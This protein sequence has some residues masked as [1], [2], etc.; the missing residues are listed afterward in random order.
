MNTA[1]FLVRVERKQVE[2]VDVFS[3]QLVSADEQR[4]PTFAAGSH[5]DVHLA[6]GLTRQYSLCNDPAESHHYLIAVL[7]DHASRG[8]SETMHRV[9]REGDLLTISAPRNHFPLAP[10]GKSSLLFAGGI[11]ITPILCMS[12]RLARTGEDFQMHYC[13]RSHERTTF[14]HRIARSAFSEKVHFHLD[15]G[16]EEQRL[17]LEALLGNPR[18]YVHV[19]V[20]GPTGFINAV[21]AK[22]RGHGWPE[23]QLHYEFF[24]T[25]LVKTGSDNGFDVKLASSG[26][27]VRVAK[28]QSV[29]QALEAAG[30]NVTTSCEQGVCGACLTRVLEGEPDHRDTYLTVEERTQN[31]D[32]L[33]CCS[34]AKSSLLVLDL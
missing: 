22:A 17:D 24:G 15:D 16:C 1:T 3:Y 6:K 20:C 32:F 21:L 29:V 11:G 19:Y 10:G 9:V 4:L 18:E 2:A 5:I 25:N 23:P 27:I 14:R 34:R 33:P 28:N 8:G 31:R 30:V 26:R 12:E 13:T 7:K